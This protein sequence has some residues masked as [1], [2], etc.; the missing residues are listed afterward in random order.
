V[1]KVSLR[2]VRRVCVLLGAFAFRAFAQEATIVGTATDPS[3][4]AVPNVSV[5]IINTGT[6]QVSHVTTNSE[7]QYLAPSLQIGRYTVRAEMA[8]FKKAE[9]TDLVLAVGDRARVDFKME[10][11]SLPPMAEACIHW[12]S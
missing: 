4:S 10:I 3:G 8:G 1:N 9:R 5:T 2:G 7:G 11:G 6:N 12:P